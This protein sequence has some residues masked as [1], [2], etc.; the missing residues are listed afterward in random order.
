MSALPLILFPGLTKGVILHLKCRPRIDGGEHGEKTMKRKMIFAIV[1]IGAIASSGSQAEGINPWAQCG[2]GAAVFEDNRPAA[3]ISNLIWD[4]GTTAITS[5]SSSKGSCQGTNVAAA[6]FI[7]DSYTQLEEETATGE[8]NHIIALLDIL[9]CGATERAAITKSVR[10]AFSEI[11]AE[12][13]YET[14]KPIERA[15]TYHGVVIDTVQSEFEKS[16]KVS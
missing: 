9:E 6:A 10:S 16:C 3:A 5:A 7:T 14:L 2:L 1:A 15:Q 13:T 4:L 11:V 12:S 8:G